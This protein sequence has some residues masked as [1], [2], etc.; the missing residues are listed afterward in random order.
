MSFTL[1]DGL[2]E[3]LKGEPDDCGRYKVLLTESEIQILRESLSMDWTSVL[4]ALIEIEPQLKKWHEQAQQA[5]AQL[6]TAYSTA[7]DPKTG[8]SE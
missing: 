1:S 3:S 4:F 2:G 5:I 8:G 7:K 6:E